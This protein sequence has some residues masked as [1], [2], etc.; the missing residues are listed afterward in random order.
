MAIDRTKIPNAGVLED[1]LSRVN[2]IFQRA[3][4][5]KGLSTNDFTNALLAQLQDL[6][7]TGGQ[8]NTIETV[9]VNGAALT[10]DASKAVD[11]TVFTKTSELTN[12]SD[13]ATNA[14]L[15]AGLNGKANKGTK[16]SDYTIGDAYT[17]TQTDSA[18]NA[19]VSGVYKVKG[20]YDTF[21]ALTAAVTAG[22]ITPVA[23]D[24]YN[25]LGAGGTDANG[26]AIK[27]GD[28]VVYVTSPAAGWDVLGG[29]TD[30]SGYAT[31]SAMTSG[32]ANKVDKVSGKGLS[33][34]DFTTALLTKLNGI[35]AA[36]TAVAV[37]AEGNGKITING[38]SK[39]VYTLPATVLQESRIMTST[40][41][42]EML[43][44]VFG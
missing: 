27:A 14:A 16:L 33:T 30:L 44:S 23:G 21:A 42:D 43:A 8:P 4:A 24:V 29:I 9:K 39:T 19:A 34:E 10:P 20:S 32:L 38:T 18:I 22:T 35:T 15:N 6:V 41:C 3:E 12:D 17:K 1:S 31:T 2:E 40:E 25:I 5:G 37:P 13:F 28:N 7:T 36:A 11:V 26:H